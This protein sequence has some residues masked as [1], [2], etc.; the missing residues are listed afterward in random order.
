MAGITHLGI[1]LMSKRI[2]PRIPVWILILCA[3]LIDVIFFVLMFAGIEE[4]P[5]TDRITYAPWSHSL[6]MAIFWTLLI[7]AI[8]YY[9]S[10]NNRTSL[11]LGLLVFS[12]WIIDFISQ[13]MTYVFP[14][15]G[16]PLLHPFGDSITLGLGVWSSELG[17]IIGE[18]GTLLLGL[19]IY[20]VTW[21]DLKRENVT[22]N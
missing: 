18:F 5:Q 1:G 3:Y 14:M 22:K 17:V 20:F 6:F 7:T 9:F 13:P 10:R 8:I 15:N 21:R 16:G 4:M 19:V 2:A 11:L 12:H